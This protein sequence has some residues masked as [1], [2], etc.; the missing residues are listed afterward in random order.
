MEYALA[1][2]DLTWLPH[3]LIRKIIV[4][5]SKIIRNIL[6]EYKVI[7]FIQNVQQTQTLVILHLLPFCVLAEAAS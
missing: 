7:S 2:L 1:F 6:T 5:Y 4:F 3:K